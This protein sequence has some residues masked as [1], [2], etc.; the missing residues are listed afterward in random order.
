MVYFDGKFS[1]AIRKAALLHPDANATDA[2]FAVEAIAPRIA[3]DAELVAAEAVMAA[4]NRRLQP[5]MPPLSARIDLI[6]GEHREARLLELELTE[7]SLFFRHAPGSVDRFV[8]TL[9]GISTPGTKSGDLG[10]P[11]ESGTA[12][13]P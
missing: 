2:L 12:G 1:H 7:P 10:R 4:M 9:L 8:E 5:S 6:L 13:T 3:S 11:I